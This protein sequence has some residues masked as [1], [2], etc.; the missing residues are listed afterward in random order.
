MTDV[1]QRVGHDERIAGKGLFSPE[2]SGYYPERSGTRTW[3]NGSATTIRI[4]GKGLFSCKKWGYHIVSRVRSAEIWKPR[5]IFAPE[6][7]HALA[8]LLCDVTAI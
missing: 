1:A 5:G 3:H 7:Q 4:A 8:A 6:R 2:R